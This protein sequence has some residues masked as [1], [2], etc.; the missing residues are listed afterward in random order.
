MKKRIIFAIIL[1]AL[2]CG[3]CLPVAGFLHA[4][5]SRQPL[6][7]DFWAMVAGV[8]R[9][10]QALR[11]W[12]LMCALCGLFCVWAMVSSTYL[13][14]K[15]GQYRVTPDISIPMPAGHGEF[16]TAWWMSGKAQRK[17]FSE[18][19][20]PKDALQDLFAA[21]DCEAAE[22]EQLRAEGLLDARKKKN[23]RRDCP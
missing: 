6:S 3:V 19:E 14:Y 10:P 9:T 15:N 1:F 23:G 22:I 4:A 17:A 7:L 16:G 13:N 20:I 12:L 18:V 8:F 2:L 21:G 11:L 5:L